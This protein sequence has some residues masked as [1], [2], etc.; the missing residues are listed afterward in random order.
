[1]TIDLRNGIPFDS[2]PAFFFDL[3]G[4]LADIAERPELVQVPTPV[5]AMLDRLSSAVDGAVAI[6]SGRSI[7]Q[8]DALVAPL[9][10]P[11]AGLHGGDLRF[12]G[13]RR[14]R[15]EPSPYIR[16]VVKGGVS[17]LVLPPGAWV[18]AKAGVAFALHHRQADG[19]GDA[20]FEAARRI[21]SQTHG[22]YTV[23]RG[24]CVVEILPAGRSKG[25]ALRR[26][27]ETH[28]F[29]DRVPVVLGD[30][31]TDEDGFVEAKLWE[32]TAISVGIRESAA[33][34]MNLGNPDAVRT[35]LT[36]VTA[37]M[38]SRAMGRWLER[39]CAA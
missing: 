33:A 4:T 20:L 17:N 25:T 32:G 27:M 38:E 31:R 39:E 14:L 16:S 36:D 35:W 10:L 8:I 28:P 29:Q 19:A 23:L 22:V 6:L 11:A 9:L 26:L 13:G 34:D 1:M 18:E 24:D 30:D 15:F 5:I 37:E 2:E 12:P 21:A 3:D 7:E